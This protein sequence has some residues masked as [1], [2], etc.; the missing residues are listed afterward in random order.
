MN[1]RQLLF[2]SLPGWTGL[3]AG[4]S[5][6]LGA[7]RSTEHKPQLEVLVTNGIEES[8]QA[9]ITASQGSTELFSNTYQLEPGY[10]DESKSVVGT[11]TKTRVSLQNGRTVTSEYSAPRPCESPEINI[12]IQPDEITV[13][14]GCITS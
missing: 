9:T 2:G 10:G 8:V 12:R 1:Q 14:N 5:S 3:L 11:P 13:N 4:C 7:D 6:L